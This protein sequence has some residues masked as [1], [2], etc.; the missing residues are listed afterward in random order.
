M[1]D[2]NEYSCEYYE[3]YHKKGR[4]SVTFC[5]IMSNVWRKGEC[6]ETKSTDYREALDR[7]ET[8]NL[9]G[10]GQIIDGIYYYIVSDEEIITDN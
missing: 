4:N 5:I 6:D 7:I 9:D 3:L 10:H 8:E 1:T 2:N